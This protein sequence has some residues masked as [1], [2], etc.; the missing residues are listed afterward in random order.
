MSNPV[1]TPE[2][3]FNIRYG[4]IQPIPGVTSA[5]G[6]VPSLGAGITFQVLFA[7]SLL[8]H[9]VHTIVYYDVISALLMAGALGTCL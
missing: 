9:L 3:R 5:Y 7:L 8:F 6:Y 4:C 1:L 2:Q